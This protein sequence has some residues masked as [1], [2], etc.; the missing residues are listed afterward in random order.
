MITFNGN[1]TIR[2]VITSTRC[3]LAS[4][5]TLI[6]QRAIYAVVAALCVGSFMHAHFNFLSID[7][8]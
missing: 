6:A 8:Q 1:R 2:N 4:R 7:H 3:T 5:I